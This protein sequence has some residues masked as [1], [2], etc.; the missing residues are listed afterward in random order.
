VTPLERINYAIN[1]MKTV[2]W[3]QGFCRKSTIASE[4]ACAYGSMITD[5]EYKGSWPSLQY[6]TSLITTEAVGDRR[7]V[8]ITAWNDEAGRTLA[9]VLDV[10]ER[11]KAKLE[12]EQQETSPPPAD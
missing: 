5:E 8:S 12:R 9:E 1:R 11:V 4:A 10:F 3:T 7:R 6:E 2:G